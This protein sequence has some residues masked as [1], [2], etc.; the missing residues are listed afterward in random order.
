MGCIETLSVVWLMIDASKSLAFII[1][2]MEY[3]IMNIFLSEDFWI[4][5]FSSILVAGVVGAFVYLTTDFL[6]APKLAMVV[7]QDNGYSEKLKFKKNAEGKYQASFVLAIQNKGN[8]TMDSMGGYWHV[9]IPVNSPSPFSVPGE[10]VHQRDYIRDLV[11]PNS[12][13]DIVAEWSLLLTEEE[14]KNPNASI[15]YFF[16]TEYGYFPKTVSMK[17]NGH[18]SRPSDLGHIKFEIV[19]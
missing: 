13:T 1:A 18:L 4:N 14:V 7:K 6:H 9:Y 10:N 19:E 2:N 16:A 11:F 17:E 8:L 15:P 5:F 12:F 3:S